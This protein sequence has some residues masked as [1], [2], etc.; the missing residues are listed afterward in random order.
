MIFHSEIWG[1]NDPKLTII[2]HEMGS[3][4]PTSVIMCDTLFEGSL[5]V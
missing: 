1:G 4:L 5:E 3:K 2:F